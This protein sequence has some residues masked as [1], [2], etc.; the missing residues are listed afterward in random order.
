ME[1]WHIAHRVNISLLANITTYSVGI[2][3]FDQ[4]SLFCTN[5]RHLAVSGLQVDDFQVDAFFGLNLETLHLSGNIIDD[6]DEPELFAHHLVAVA[7]GQH[8]LWKVE[9][10][11]IYGGR[12]KWEAQYSD[13]ELNLFEWSSADRF[14]S[15]EFDG[16][17]YP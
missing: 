17:P 7:E 11:Y 15:A 14:A 2:L 5:L 4:L 16:T 10:I 1:I 8:E 3:A 13:E 12:K 6:L 9:K